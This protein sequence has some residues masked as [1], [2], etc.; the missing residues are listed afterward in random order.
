MKKQ[1]K[2]L[3]LNRETLRALETP[4]LK[5]YAGGLTMDPCLTNLRSC[6]SGGGAGGQ[7]CCTMYC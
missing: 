1:L 6:N 4:E 3:N 7:T 5:H 2:K